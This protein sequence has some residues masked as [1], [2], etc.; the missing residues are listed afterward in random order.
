MMMPT[1]MVAGTVSNCLA[2]WFETRIPS[3]LCLT[4]A[5]AS[6]TVMTPLE[7]PG[8]QENKCEILIDLLGFNGVV[9]N[10]RKKYDNFYDD[11]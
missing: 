7:G 6:S 9:G 2:P 3:T 5:N 8:K 11:F 1:S 4:E 10:T